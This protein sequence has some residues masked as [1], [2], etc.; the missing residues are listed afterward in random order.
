M[1]VFLTDGNFILK[2]K[3]GRY[4]AMFESFTVR[5]VSYQQKTEE[6]RSVKK[7]FIV[8]FSV[9][10]EGSSSA[11]KLAA[12]EHFCDKSPFLPFLL[13]PDTN[14]TAMFTKKR[15]GHYLP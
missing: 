6:Q 4:C 9:S 8:L 1:Y 13:A 11:T 7:I 3:S 14:V 15:G 2:E 10:S 12:C 5:S